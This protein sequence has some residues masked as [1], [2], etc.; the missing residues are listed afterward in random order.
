MG[1]LFDGIASLLGLRQQAGFEGQAAMQL[2]WLATE[3]KAQLA[4][5]SKSVANCYPMPVRSSATDRVLDWEPLLRGV[6]GDLRN[7]LPAAEVSRKFHESLVEAIVGLA[8]L[9]ARNKVVLSGGCFQNKYLLE[10][11]V[12]RLREAGFEPDWHRWVPPNDGGIALGQIVAARG[13]RY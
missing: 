13:M 9:A 7:G 8:R 2:E 4:A 5:D 12:C 3:S 6:L 1:R 10:R 11:T